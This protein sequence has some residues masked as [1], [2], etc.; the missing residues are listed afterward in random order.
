MQFANLIDDSN[1]IAYK[2]SETMHNTM[3]NVQTTRGFSSS[4]MWNS[5][6]GRLRE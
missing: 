2:Y 5:S 6:I 4:S 1:K 3:F